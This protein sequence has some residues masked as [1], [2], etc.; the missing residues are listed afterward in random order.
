MLTR[1]LKR[2]LI[3]DGILIVLLIILQLL[4]L[5][6]AFIA[7]SWFCLVFLTIVSVISFSLTARS[8]LQSSTQQFLMAITLSFIAKF[9]LCIT[10]IVAYI[11]IVKPKS[12]LIVIPFFI[13][14]SVFTCLEVSELFSLLKG[15]KEKQD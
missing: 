3:T 13:F 7:F 11:L 2:L 6:P 9:V 5:I 4:A 12:L 8:A 10:G 15:L 1:F 14:Y